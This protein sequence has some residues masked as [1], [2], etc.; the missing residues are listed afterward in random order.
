MDNPIVS[1]AHN[2]HGLTTGRYQYGDIYGFIFNQEITPDL[3]IEVGFNHEKHF[4]DFLNMASPPG[5]AIRVDPNLF[6]PD[7]ATPNPYRGMW[8]VEDWGQSTLDYNELYGGRA[9]IS[10]NL[11]LTG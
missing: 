5:A 7:G 11:D 1:A 8:Y 4:S 10:Y 3:H 6:L 9:T 2:I